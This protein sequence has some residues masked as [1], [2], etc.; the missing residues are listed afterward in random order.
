M[1]VKELSF[2]NYRNLADSTIVPSD[3]V[4]V[5]YG[6]NANGKTNLLE[7]I[8]LFC[9][10]HSFR[11]SKEN[12]MI[13]FEKDFFKLWMKFDSGEREQEAQI[14]FDKSR[15]MISI[16]G[17]EK[18]SSSYLTEVFS[19]VVFSPEHLSLIK[20]G[21]NIRRKFLDAAICQHRIRYA[22]QLA[23]YNQII[24]QRNALLKDIYKHPELKDTL[25]IWDDS[26]IAAGA[27]ILKERFE[28]LKLMKEPA[29]EYHSGI[30]RDKEE[31][32]I[33]YLCTAKAT[34]DDSLD[35]IREKLRREFKA[36]RHEDYRTGYTSV[37]P[38]RDD[39]DF[40]IN[41]ISARRFGSQGQQ[42]SAVL[43]L[44]LSEAELLYRKN[45]ERPVILLDDVLSELDNNRQ[46]FLLNKVGDY[47][48]F[49]TCCEESN[50]EQLKNGKVFYIE[51]GVVSE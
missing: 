14:I 5:I 39:L 45:G 50:K 17:V 41:G 9:G 20:R 24:N 43:S 21:P 34:E 19:A 4:N 15:K 2:T 8:W 37:G 40:K 49:V 13:L 23:K 32:S 47:Q 25:C 48:V 33:E 16:N 38:H 26:L 27:L 36:S 30:S 46:D 7:A 51:N 29:R 10:G 6:E 3:N 42:R 44:K 35:D 18:S 11:G 31:L 12:E 28:Y 1:K 22:S